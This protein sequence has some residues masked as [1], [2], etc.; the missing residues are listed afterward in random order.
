MAGRSKDP[1]A[2][3]HVRMPKSVLDELEKVAQKKGM[4]TS[5][6]ARWVLGRVLEGERIKGTQSV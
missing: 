1:S 6:Y 5:A 4:T 3:L 2:T